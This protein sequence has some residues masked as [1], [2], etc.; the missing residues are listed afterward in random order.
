M[1]EFDDERVKRRTSRAKQQA[2]EGRIKD[3]DSGRNASPAPERQAALRAASGAES[4]GIRIHRD[5]E[6]DQM[7][8]SAGARA[9]ARGKDV[10]F[11]KDAYQPSTEEGRRLISH[12]VAHVLQ[13]N[14]DGGAAATRQVLEREADAAAAQA[15][16]GEP[17]IVRE[18][19]APGSMLLKEEKQAAPSI[20]E[21]AEEITPVI[22]RGTISGPG[23]SVTYQYTVIKGARGITLALSVPQGIGVAV[24]PLADV[25]AGEIRVQ[26]SDG[27]NARTVSVTVTAG[28]KGTP[29]IQV[30]FTKGSSAYLVVFHLPPGSEKK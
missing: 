24:S 4:A 9:L 7:A 3:R 6:A 1:T 18:R 8:R 10:F 15:V 11:R 16:R 17:A 26:G 22:P 12:E 29:C 2:R 27:L 19:A 25:S 28:G 5:Q 20:A 13:Q 23:F 21:H 14:Q 30:N